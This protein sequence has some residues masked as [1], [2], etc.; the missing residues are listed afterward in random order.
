MKGIGVKTVLIMFF[1]TFIA[2]APTLSKSK[3]SGGPKAAINQLLVMQAEAWNR[4]DLTAFMTGYLDSPDTSYTS[5]GAE[6]WGYEAIHARYAKAYGTNSSAM[7]KLKFSNLRIVEVGKDS[8]FCVGQFFLEKPDASK[9]D[10]VFS[11]VLKKTPSG[12][13]IIHDHTTAGIKKAE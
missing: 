1:V 5:G 8:A 2:V 7:G 13:K 3:D 11:L 9:T 10:G 6:V 12:W 4:G